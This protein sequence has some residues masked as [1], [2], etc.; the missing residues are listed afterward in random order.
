M[1]FNS[2]LVG[3][4]VWNT[5][6]V[7]IIP[8]GTLNS[9]RDDALDRFINGADGTNGVTDIKLHFKTYSYEGN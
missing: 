6:W 2:R 4:S 5:Q 9:D 8:A 1:T 3:R 7:L